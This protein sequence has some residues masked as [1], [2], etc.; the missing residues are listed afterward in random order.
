MAIVENTS[1]KLVLKSGSTV[2]TLDK[3]AGKA[4]MQRKMMFMNLKP[5]EV[6]LK[7]ITDVTL[8]LGMDRASGIE[9]CNAM[10]ITRTGAGL[11]VGAADKKDAEATAAAIKKFLGLK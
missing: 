5:V 1:K 3:D 9:I 2:F 10:V 4:V 11:A 8:D 6:D 7:D